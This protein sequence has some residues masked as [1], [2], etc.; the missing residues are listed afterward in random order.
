MQLHKIPAQDLEDWKSFYERMRDNGVV[1]VSYNNVTDIY[2]R[3]VVFTFKFNEDKEL[4]EIGSR[5]H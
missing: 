2:Y 3:G 1:F 4:A 5:N